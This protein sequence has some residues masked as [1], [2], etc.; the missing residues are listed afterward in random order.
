MIHNIILKVVSTISYS[1]TIYI[2]DLEINNILQVHYA[3]MISQL[4][5][6][7]SIVIYNS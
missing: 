6:R 3:F 7:N 4:L 2:I 1:N 5:Y